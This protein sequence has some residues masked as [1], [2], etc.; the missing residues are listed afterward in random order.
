MCIFYDWEKLCIAINT[1]ALIAKTLGR[2]P[3]K[4]VCKFSVSLIVFI[5][6][7]TYKVKGL[8]EVL[9]TFSILI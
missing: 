2:N 6:R 4:Y 8:I 9:P 7:Q 3:S 5:Y 1:T